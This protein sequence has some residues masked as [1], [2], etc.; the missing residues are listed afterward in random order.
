MVFRAFCRST[1]GLILLLAPFAA[2]ADDGGGRD[3]PSDMPD[4]AAVL[5]AAPEDTK[6]A[7]SKS[8]VA[9]SSA[10]QP[11]LVTER[12]PDGS[13]RI[14]RTVVLDDES[15]FVNHGSYAAYDEKGEVQVAGQYRMGKQHGLWKRYFDAGEENFVWGNVDHQFAGP[16]LSEASFVDGQLHGSWI[17]LSRGGQKILEWRFQDGYCQGSATQWYASGTKQWEVNFKDGQPI[18]E[19][20]E[21]GPRGELLRSVLFIDGCVSVKHEKRHRTGQR[22]CAGHVLI[23]SPWSRL[24]FDWWNTRVTLAPL[25][26]TL[27]ERRHGLWTEWYSDGTKKFEGEYHE[28]T[29]HGA[30]TWWSENGEKRV[31]GRYTKG[32]KD[33]IWTT[34]NSSGRKDSVAEYAAGLQFWTSRR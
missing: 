11:E 27:P 28:G 22:S 6:I 17:I 25:P 31:E 7:P 13:V 34:W 33:G 4:Q 21:W 19:F 1:F 18:G 12:Y 29:P 32:R 14:Q 26:A 8:N 5:P 3:A 2:L 23:P 30:F 15:N 24:V 10:R 9:D 20:G 16:Y